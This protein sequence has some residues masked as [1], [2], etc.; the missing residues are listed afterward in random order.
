A[1]DARAP[2]RVAEEGF[3]RQ[4]AIRN[5]VHLGLRIGRTGAGVP[6]DPGNVIRGGRGD[7]QVS[8]LTRWL[9]SK[10]YPSFQSNWDDD[11]FRAEI[12]TLL[13]PEHCL[14]DLGAGAGIVPQMNFKGLVAR[15]CGVDPDE[16]VLTNPYLDE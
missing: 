7:E 3:Q 10:L 8:N 4:E 6:R 11:M 15:V 13:R 9:D 1:L 14:L 2:G 12:L 16:R 5:A